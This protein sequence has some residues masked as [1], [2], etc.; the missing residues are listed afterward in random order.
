MDRPGFLVEVVVGA[1]GRMMTVGFDG[2][3]HGQEVGV[4]LLPGQNEER[5]RQRLQ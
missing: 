1:L 3:F 4:L 5:Q 2:E